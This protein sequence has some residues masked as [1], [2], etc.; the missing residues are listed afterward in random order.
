MFRFG[1]TIFVELAVSPGFIPRPSLSVGG[2][3]VS[4]DR[5]QHRN[6]LAIAS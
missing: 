5:D 2:F 6:A 4:P 3:L 1:T